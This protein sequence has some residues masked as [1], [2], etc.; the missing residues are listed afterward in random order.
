MH[1]ESAPSGPLEGVQAV[2]ASSTSI[3]V[4]W[5]E[6]ESI[7]QNGPQIL[8]EILFSPITDLP[9]VEGGTRNTTVS[10]AYDLNALEEN[11]EYNI[12]MRSFTSVGPGPYSVV[13]SNTTFQDGKF[14]NNN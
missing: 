5:E 13:V 12:S 11:V 6:V 14:F 10:G 7:N 4:L 2:S 9:G 1:I 3:T 8:Y